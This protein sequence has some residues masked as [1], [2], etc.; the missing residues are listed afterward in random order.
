MNPAP[1]VMRMFLGV[2]M[3]V[4]AKMLFFFLKKNFFFILV[5]FTLLV[6]ESFLVVRRSRLDRR[7]ARG[8]PQE[9]R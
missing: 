2:Y 9:A 4:E 3:E 7:N 8:A 6:D 5:S 1:P